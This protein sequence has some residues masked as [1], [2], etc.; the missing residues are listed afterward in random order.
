MLQSLDV[1]TNLFVVC[2]LYAH[3]L[4]CVYLYVCVLCVFFVCTENTICYTRAYV[5][6]HSCVLCLLGCISV[7]ACAYVLVC[8][9]V[10]THI[11][12]RARARV[13]VHA[14]NQAA[15]LEMLQVYQM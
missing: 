13:C 5:C 9:C 1:C 11:H 3:E 15:I 6:M 7:Y 4:A 8:L 12:A 2:A 14:F 10:M